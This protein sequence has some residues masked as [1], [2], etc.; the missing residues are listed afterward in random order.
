[1]TEAEYTRKQ[2]TPPC[3]DRAK[4]G[5]VRMHVF[6][7]DIKDGIIHAKTDEDG[8]LW[9]ENIPDGVECYVMLGD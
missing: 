1:M 5:I 4:C 6:G 7:D 2:D 3:S 8:Y 9:V